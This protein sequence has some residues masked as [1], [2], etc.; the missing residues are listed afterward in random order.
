MFLKLVNKRAS[1]IDLNLYNS[2]ISFLLKASCRPQQDTVEE[3]WVKHDE[4]TKQ[5]QE[6]LPSAPTFKRE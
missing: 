3:K 2:S 4:T 5:T 1:L 6:A